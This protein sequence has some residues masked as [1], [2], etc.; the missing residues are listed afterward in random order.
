[1]AKMG[2][3]V[4]VAPRWS[5]S[6]LLVGLER[7]KERQYALGEQCRSGGVVRRERGVGEEMLLPRV[8]EQLGLF[9]RVDEGSRGLEVLGEERV[10]VLAMHLRWDAIGPR[11]PELRDWETRGHEQGAA[12][13]GP[14]LRELLGDHDPER[15]ASVDGLGADPL[16]G[17]QP[18]L[19]KRAEAGF[20]REGH[21]LLDRVERA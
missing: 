5:H 1:M 6:L 9:G 13:A 14:R 16:G 8:E 2:S 4:T 15:E 19:G 21:A 3:A 7:V 11:V 20:A 17:G 12:G 18:A 10:G